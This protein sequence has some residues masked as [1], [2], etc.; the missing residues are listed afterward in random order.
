MSMSKDLLSDYADVYLPDDGP[1]ARGLEF[2]EGWQPVI[3]EYL[4]RLRDLH[5]NVRLRWAKEKFGCLRVFCSS[6]RKLSRLQSHWLDIENERVRR[7]SLTVCHECGQSGRLRIG[8]YHA[9]LCDQ[10]AYNVGDVR[11]ELVGIRDP[12]R[13]RVVDGM[14]VRMAGRGAVLDLPDA[15]LGLDEG[16]TWDAE[17]A[18]VVRFLPYIFPGAEL[19]DDDLELANLADKLMMVD[20][21]ISDIG[22]VEFSLH[23]YRTGQEIDYSLSV[24]HG[25]DDHAMR[26]EVDRVIKGEM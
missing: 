12:E 6:E 8:L 25:F 2:K 9:T 13:Q 5:I 1:D 15:A 22:D 26:A 4:D 3:R 18:F 14:L 20:A 10:H 7:K 21:A 11:P 19:P 16:K 24:P 23:V 17:K